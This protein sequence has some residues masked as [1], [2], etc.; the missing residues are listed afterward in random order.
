[1]AQHRAARPAVSGRPATP[2]APRAPRRPRR[3]GADGGFFRWLTAPTKRRWLRISVVIVAVPTII[4]SLM[5]GYYYIRFAHMIDARL[6]GEQRPMPRIFGRPFQIEAGQPV[7]IG[8]LEQRLNDDGYAER[9][10]PEHPGEF[11]AT[12]TSVTLI[13]RDP[14]AKKPIPVRVEFSRGAGSVVTKLSAV[15]GGAVD[16]VTLEAPL[17]TELVTGQKA[18]YVKLASIPKVMVQAVIAI[19][20]KRFFEHPGVDPIRAVGAILTNLR[21]KKTYLEG[22]STL[23]Q[24]IV[25]NTFLTQ[26]KTMRRK[27]AEQFIALVVEMRLTKEQI[28]ELYLNET[29]IGQRGPFEIHG[30]AEAARLFFGKD[31]ANITV[32]EA[33]T[34]A[35]VIHSPSQ[36]S[37]FR[38]P[39]RAVERR[40]LVLK[41]M[42]SAGFITPEAAAKA[43]K[44]PL[45]L[46]A[47]ALE[48]EAPYFVDYVGQQL[49]EKSRTLMKVKDAAFDVYTTVD[50][51]LQRLAQ[52]AVAEGMTQVDKQLAAHKRPGQAEVAMVVVDPKTGDILALVG[53]RGYNESQYDRAAVSQRQPGSTFKPF[54]YLA[55]F[56]KMADEGKSDLTPATVMVDEPTTFLFEDKEYSPGNYENEYDGPITLR[57]ALAHSRNVVAVKVAE[58]TGYD[59]VAALWQ[60]IDAGTTAKPYPAIALGVFEASPIEMAT[61]Y[62]IFPNGGMLRPL[63]AITHILESGKT[64]PVPQE[65]DKTIARPETTFLVTNMMRSVLNEGTGAAAREDG[66]KLDA[67]GKTGTTSDLR[68]AWFVGFTPDLLTVVWV[69]FDDN[70]PIGLTGAQAALPIWTA[71]MKRALA[72]HA[73]H[74]FEVPGGVVFADIDRDNGKLATPYCPYV[75][76]ESFLPGTEPKETCDIHKGPSLLSKI[77]QWLRK[78]IRRP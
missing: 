71:F 40:N 43:S 72:G 3:G 69:G 42:A 10:K 33:A 35:G 4:L 15:G 29:L 28:L 20:D 30:V 8:E 62:T 2:R 46:T 53:G 45:Q 39:D 26:E 31:I 70:K 47:R 61:A 48:N 19:E 73:D 1:L 17:L 36:L 24:Q 76:S 12:A 25:K 58:A 11:S 18:R 23:T 64:H 55:A 56:E 38:H 65:K 66:F 9:A 57:H 77:G 54:V 51:H 60:S 13:P 5:L 32:A 14:A 50:L 44:E 67:A 52:E 68:D 6:G 78:V 41:E 22:A 75:I 27:V 34:I 7:S 21:G 37:P 63:H 59:R 49:D 16:H 74:A